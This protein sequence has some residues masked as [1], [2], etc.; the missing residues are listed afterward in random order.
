MAEEA[1]ARRRLAY[2]VIG[3]NTFVGCYRLATKITFA[4]SPVAGLPV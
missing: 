3:L 2:E 4:S 1:V